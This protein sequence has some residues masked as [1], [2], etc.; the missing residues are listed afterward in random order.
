VV[1]VSAAV[2]TLPLVGSAPLQPP[3]AVHAVALAV[4]HVSIAVPP[5]VTLAGFAVSVTVGAGGSD[6]GLLPEEQAVN[7]RAALNNIAKLK[8]RHK[9]FPL[10]TAPSHRMDMTR[11]TALCEFALASLRP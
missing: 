10:I 4:L 11:Y 6:D 9:I 3:E 8:N 1:A 5:E 2:D 7:I